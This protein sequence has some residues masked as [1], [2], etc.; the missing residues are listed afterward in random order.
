MSM[1]MFQTT[2]ATPHTVVIRARKLPQHLPT[3]TWKL[4]SSSSASS[5]YQKKKEARWL[6]ASD[7]PI[8][9]CKPTV[10]HVSVGCWTPSF[11][12]SP[13]SSSP[14]LTVRIR[15]KGDQEHYIAEVEVANKQEQGVIEFNVTFGHASNYN[16]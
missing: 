13:T 7:S 2:P 6:E 12:S 1:M 5:A 9:S 8:P 14:P 10:I 3:Q 4:P 16:L 11:P 15:Q